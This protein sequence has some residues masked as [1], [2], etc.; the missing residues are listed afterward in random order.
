MY[1]L[2]SGLHSYSEVNRS[3]AR[4]SDRAD[5]AHVLEETLR[6]MNASV[7]ECGAQIT[8]GVLPDV[9]VPPAQLGQVFQ[10]LLSNA[11]KYRKPD[12]Q[13]TVHIRAIRRGTLWEFSVKDNGIGIDPTYGDQ[14]FGVFRRLHGREVPGTGI[15]LA[16]VKK[17]IESAGGQVWVVSSVG[18]GADFR[19][20]L[21]GA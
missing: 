17:I 2:V 9:M 18:E 7:L 16:I 15:G 5:A 21:A 11:I 20:T 6:N 12:V 14:I 13:L 1:E 8:V 10:N 19:F 3:P 4:P